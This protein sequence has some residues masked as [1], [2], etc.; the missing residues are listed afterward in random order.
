MGTAVLNPPLTA[1]WVDANRFVPD[2]HVPAEFRFTYADRTPVA[3]FVNATWPVISYLPVVRTMS[4]VLFVELS[5]E[6]ESPDY[7]MSYTSASS[8]ITVGVDPLFGM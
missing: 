4:R 5:C 6:G 3:L 1:D 7:T 2:P 8:A